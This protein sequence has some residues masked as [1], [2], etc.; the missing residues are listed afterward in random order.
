[1]AI[2]GDLAHDLRFDERFF[3]YFEDV[4]LCQRAWSL[5]A[6]VGVCSTVTIEHTSGWRHE[7]PLIAN[8]G[9]E[10]ARS[11]ISYAEAY[12]HS[13]QG[14][15]ISVLAWALPR[16]VFLGRSANERA[17]SQAIA[18]GMMHSRR[19]GIA[20]LAL[21]HNTRYGFTVS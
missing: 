11:A 3:M 8:R 20:E 18:G 5:G 9:V 17:Q 14:M 21:S 2:R 16:T 15:K 13:T 4:D 19:M 6:R 12:G 10:Y 1:M 7:D